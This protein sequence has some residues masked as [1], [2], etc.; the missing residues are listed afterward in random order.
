MDASARGNEGRKGKGRFREQPTSA[1]IP[2][3]DLTRP[4]GGG[5]GGGGGHG[6]GHGSDGAAAAADDDDDDDGYRDARL[7]NAHT[8]AQHSQPCSRAQQYAP[9]TRQPSTAR[10]KTRA[11]NQSSHWP[12]LSRTRPP[13]DCYPAWG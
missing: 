11:L 7:R 4:G 3:R 5:G 9:P 2:I 13:L 1:A 6:H 12:P 10:I 8:P